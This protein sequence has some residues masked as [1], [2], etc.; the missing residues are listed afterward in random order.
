[1]LGIVGIIAFLT[2]LGL[3]LFITRLATIALTYTGLS[4]EAARFQ[5]RSAFTG[6]GFTTSEAERVVDH[7]VRRRIIMLLMIARSAGV[8]SIIISL[9]LSFGG[10][11]SD[12][13]RLYR[14]LWIIGGVAVLLAAAKSDLIDRTLSRTIRWALKK[15]TA[16]DVHDYTSLLKL[17]G[18]YMVTEIHVRKGDWLVGRTLSEC[19]LP[20]EGMIVLGIYRVDDD[21]IGIP[22][23]ETEIY[24]NDTLVI[25]GRSKTLRELE[26][27][28]ADRSGDQAHANSVREQK[29]HRAEQEQRERAHKQKQR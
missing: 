23:G 6:T 4:W 7:P 1:M 12:L 2:V 5:A 18:E 11:Q 25:Y 24:A 17:S 14:L 26:Q 10:Y 3:S 28:R 27:R 22:R 8:V 13:G 9:I 19:R 20:Q 29:K 16:L 15:W 21:Y